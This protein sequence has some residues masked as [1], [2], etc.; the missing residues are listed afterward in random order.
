MGHVCL[1]RSLIHCASPQTVSKEARLR[2]EKLPRLEP[3]SV[4]SATQDGFQTYNVFGS[5]RT[6]PAKEM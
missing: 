1:V 4:A 3:T 2:G 5:Q 6:V